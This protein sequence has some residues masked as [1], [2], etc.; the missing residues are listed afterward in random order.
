[1]DTDLLAREVL[2]LP[3]PDRARLAELLLSSLDDLPEAEIE[4]LWAAEAQRRAAELRDGSVQP[5]TADE[6]RQRVRA[7]LA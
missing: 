5:V 4:R 3:A 2:A 1:M 6:L 7:L